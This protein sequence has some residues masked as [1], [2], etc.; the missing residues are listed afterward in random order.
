MSLLYY[1]LTWIQTQ[2]YLTWS[3]F[4]L[5]IITLCLHQLMRV[6][7][8]VVML[9][10]TINLSLSL[11]SLLA[12]CLLLEWPGRLRERIV[13]IRFKPSCQLLLTWLSAGCFIL[14]LVCCPLLLLL[15]PLEYSLLH[16]TQEQT[17]LR[18]PPLDTGWTQSRSETN[19]RLIEISRYRLTH[20]HHYYHY[21]YHAHSTAQ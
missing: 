6:V 12:L 5:L 10:T 3:S 9:L 11:P 8:V 21:Y 18:V 7:L 14:F 17:L 4:Y 15:L 20:H 2:I 16:T 19:I 1:L 13:K